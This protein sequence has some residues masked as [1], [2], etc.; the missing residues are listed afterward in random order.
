MI[1]LPRSL[2]RSPL[3]SRLLAAQSARSFARSRGGVGVGVAVGFGSGSDPRA[4]VAKRCA[5]K[6]ASEVPASTPHFYCSKRICLYA[7]DPHK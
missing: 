1:P 2:A 7:P 4:L 5:A 3:L 6:R